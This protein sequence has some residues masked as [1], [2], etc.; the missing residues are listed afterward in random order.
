MKLQIG[1]R[2]RVQGMVGV[3]V[4]LIPEGEFAPD[5]PAEE[6]AYLET[7]I[8]VATEE[9]GLVHYPSLEGIEIDQLSN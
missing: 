7:G 5:L 6:W 1:D 9:A 3:V 4:A 2:I 8:M